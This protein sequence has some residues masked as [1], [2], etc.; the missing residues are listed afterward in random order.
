MTPSYHRR[1][2]RGNSE[3]DDD[4]DEVSVT[5]SLSSNYHVNNQNKYLIIRR[6][7]TQKNGEKSWQQEVVRDP[8]VIK[9]YL[10]Q[11][12]MIEEEATR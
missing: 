2:E 10:R 4:D 6:L 9:S 7:I 8:V 12:Q 11:R 5:G 3:F 1:F